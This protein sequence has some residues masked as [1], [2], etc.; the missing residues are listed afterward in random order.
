M[1]F[2]FSTGVKKDETTVVI[3]WDHPKHGDLYSFEY[4]YFQ[5]P[6]MAR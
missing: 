2:V 1:G 5:C 4:L 3:D 6:A